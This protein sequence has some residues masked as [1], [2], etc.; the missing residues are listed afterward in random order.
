MS[1]DLDEKEAR[2]ARLNAEIEELTKANKELYDKA[3][4]FRETVQRAE[5]LEEKKSL[6]VENMNNLKSTMTPLD[7]ECC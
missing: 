3:T 6:H 5:T 4:K 7:G 1:R 2:L